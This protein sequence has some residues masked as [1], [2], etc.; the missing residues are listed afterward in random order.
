MSAP[1]HDTVGQLVAGPEDRYWSIKARP[2]FRHRLGS[3]AS[4]LGL[5]V[6]ALL[7]PVIA[8]F[9][10]VAS[11]ITARRRRRSPGLPA[12]AAHVLARS[13]YRRFFSA[14]PTAVYSPLAKSLELGYF[15]KYPVDAPSLEIGVGDGLFTTNLCE[16][17]RRPISLGTDLIYETLSSARA[18]TAHETLFVSDAHEIPVAPSSVATVI[19][20]NLMHHL[21]E[22]E[23]VT[24]QVHRVLRPGG[25]F[26]FTDNLVGWNDFMWDH[27]LLR[28]VLPASW[29]RRYAERKL[30][31]LAQS[32]LVSPAYWRDF[33]ARG[34]W[35]VVEVSPFVSRTAMTVASLF[36]FL[37]LKFGQPTR[38]PLRRLLGTGWRRTAMSALMGRIVDDLIV[39]DERLC[40]QEGAA[41]LFVALRK[42]GAPGEVP[43]EPALACPQCKERFTDE[44]L[45]C[46]RCGKAYPTVNGIPILLSYTERLPWLR[47]YLAYQEGRTPREF[48]T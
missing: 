25:M 13:E 16:I 43:A 22:R 1:S 3:A 23:R 24:A 30:W 6:F 38:P 20:N 28:R 9:G 48:V 15:G 4:A 39:M 45:A 26:L 10:W 18:R 19:M 46:A 7:L 2:A 34:D 29:L 11:Q 35:D 5:I 36:E 33:A 40:A 44:R 21:A 37:N 42:R 41:F 31:L 47:E 27:R 32:L 17:T 12:G 14:Y 8:A